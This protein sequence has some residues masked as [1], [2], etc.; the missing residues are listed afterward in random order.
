MNRSRIWI[1]CVTAMAEA[2][3]YGISEKFEIANLDV[4]SRSLDINLYNNSASITVNLANHSEVKNEIPIQ[5]PNASATDR[6]SNEHP[7]KD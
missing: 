6:P 2:R 1:D 4:V 7:T 5:T 3:F